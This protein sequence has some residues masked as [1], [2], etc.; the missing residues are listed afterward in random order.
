MHTADDGTAYWSARDL[1]DAMG[2]DTWQ[3][4]TP[5]VERAMETA[6][7]MNTAVTSAFRG[8]TNRVP[9]GDGFTNRRDY[10]LS[11]FAAYLVP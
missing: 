4:F 11:R 2:Y 3:N 7:N 8:V 9:A 10:H 5:A 1:A 6:S